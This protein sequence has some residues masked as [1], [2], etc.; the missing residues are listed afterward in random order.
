MAFYRG[1]ISS[2]IDLLFLKS[3][4]IHTHWLFDSGIF[5][6]II[7]Y[8]SRKY[9]FWGFRLK[10][11]WF[12]LT[13]LDKFFFLL[14]STFNFQLDLPIR[15]LPPRSWKSLLFRPKNH[16][17]LCFLQFNAFFS[18]GMVVTSTITFIVSTLEDFKDEDEWDP[19]S[20]LNLTVDYIDI[21][22]IIF[23][24]LE[25]LLRFVL[26]PRKWKFIK[27]PMNMVDLIAI[28]PFY[29]ALALN[30]LEDIQIIGMLYVC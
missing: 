13:R 22:V 25:Y 2:S 12:D 21:I 8:F 4:W 24:T 28:M 29:M 19:N 1:N 18:L 26:S 3:A 15:I 23:F 11:L 7:I 10:I 30:H 16:I 9:P 20:F 17:V 14:D 5:C 6:A 27:D